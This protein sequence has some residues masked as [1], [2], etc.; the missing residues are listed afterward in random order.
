MTTTDIFSED[1]LMQHLGAELVIG[2]PG[3]VV[4]EL[5]V[6]EHLVQRHNTCQGGAIF[7]L[8][9]AAFG[10]AANNTGQSA[11]S[12]HCT[13]SFLRPAPLGETIRAEAKRRSTTGRTDIFDVEVSDSSGELI[14]EFRGNAHILKSTSS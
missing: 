10:I 8:A 7:A 6:T 3:H 5:E 12:Q 2:E 9:D 14:A 1:K 11:V 4:I 13:I